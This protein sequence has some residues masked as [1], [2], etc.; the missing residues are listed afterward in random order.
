MKFFDT[1]TNEY[2]NEMIDFMNIYLKYAEKLRLFR[3]MNDFDISSGKLVLSN[4]YN[5]GLGYHHIINY[6][7]PVGSF[8]AIIYKDSF[9][10]VLIRFRKP[11]ADSLI[12]LKQIHV[13]PFEGDIIIDDYQKLNPDFKSEEFN[14]NSS[15][16]SIMDID[17]LKEYTLRKKQNGKDCK[18]IE[19]D[20]FV[21]L[22]NSE[23]MIELDNF[24]TGILVKPHHGKGIYFAWVGIG[25]DDEIDFLLID[26]HMVY[27]I[28]KK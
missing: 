19:V 6:N 26:L 5:S 2:K 1:R 10:S 17:S 16:I 22:P 20:T 25:L 15:A 7:F 4:L 21:N 8:P 14:V 13:T 12:E 11:N 27:S 23:K 3:F 24:R 18:I 9:Q 28:G